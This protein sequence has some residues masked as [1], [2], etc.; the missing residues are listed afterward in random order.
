M[1]KA[2]RIVWSAAR[3]AWVVAS[4]RAGSGGR[5]PL[6][7]KKAACA[8]LLLGSGIASL[9]VYAVTYTGTVVSGPGISQTLNSG[10]TATGVT[11]TSSANQYVSSGGLATSTAVINGGNQ[12]IFAGGSATS[13][14]LSGSRA[15][16]YVS[17]GGVATG[18]TVSNSA[19][20]RVSAGGL[21]TLT[22]LNS[23]GSLAVEPNGSVLGL[24]VNSGG[25]A[26]IAGGSASAITVNSGGFF[27]V[28]GGGVATS[29]NQLA[30]AALNT[31][32][33][34][35]I[36]GTNSLGAFSISAG[37]ANNLLLENTGVFGV[38]SGTSA[39]NTTVGSAGVAVVYSGG[40]A[41]GTTVTTNGSQ[42][43]L[44]GGSAT[45]TVING[46]QETVTGTATGTT[47]NL[48]GVQFV[49]AGGVASGTIINAYGEQD[50][51]GSATSTTVNSSGWQDVF[52][53]ADST[54]VNS[55][56][57]Q[58]V[59]SG[60]SASATTVEG[61]NQFVLN[62]GSVTDTVVNSG[63]QLNT[64][65]SVTSATLNSGGRA[66]LYSG[67]STVA[68]QINSGG[69]EYVNSGTLS[70]SAVLN[71]GGYQVVYAGGEAVAATVSGGTQQVFGEATS[72]TL[73]SGGAQYVYSSGTATGTQ[74]GSGAAQGIYG[75]ANSTTVTSGGA[76]YVYNGGTANWTTVTNNGY[77]NINS[78]G[79][80]SDATVNSGGTL[81]ANDGASATGL[82]LASG[83]V[84]ITSTGAALAGTN[85]LGAFSISGGQAQNVLLENNGFL[86]VKSGDSSIGTVINQGGW[87]YV[88]GHATGTTVNSGGVQ[89]VLGTVTSTTVNSGGTLSVFN[90]GIASSSII[91]DGGQL[92]VSSGGTATDT[93]VAAGGLL[94]IADGG[95]LTLANSS[96]VNDGVTTYDT[97]TSASLNT[98]ISGSGQLT[99]NGSGTLTLGGTFSQSQVNLNDGALIM[100]GLQATTDIVAQSGTS[101]SL[102]NSTTLTG[103]IDPTDVNIDQSSSWNITGDS[104][105]DTL[106][107]AGS[108][109]FVPSQ[110]A[111]TPYTLTVTNLVGNGGTITL[112]TVAGD[113]SSPIDKVVIDGGQA[114]GSTGLLVLN[115]GGLGAQTTGNGIAVIQAINGGTTDVGAFTLNQP[116]VAGAYS[117]SL[118]RNADQSWYLTSQLT[119]TPAT[120]TG[121][122]TPDEGSSDT[123][124]VS[125]TTNYR[126]GM[127]SYA[128]LPSLSLDFDRLVAGT[129]DTRFHYAQDS[130]V[131]GRLVAGHL[132]HAD[133]GSLTGG[134]VP[135]S[136]SAYSFLQLGG[137][138]WQL[139]GA[140]AD[141][142]AGLYGAT[143][144][145]R[146][147]VWRDGGSHAAGTDR[148]TSYTG[149]LYLSGHSHAGLHVDGVLQASHH[150]L[151]TNSNDGT[152][153]STDGTGWLASAEV[154]QAFS[155]GSNLSLE[156]QLQYT[157]QGLS[158][159]DAQ[160]EAASLSWS[161]THRQSVRA[162][163]KVGSSQDAKAKLS[164][165][166]T[167]SI[168]QSYGG[169]S[170]VTASVPGVAGSEASFRSNLSGTGV[171]INGGLDARIRQN[172]T[173]GVQGGWSDALHGAESGGYYGQVRLGVSF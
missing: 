123:T 136:S 43:I 44:A 83:A 107:N 15:Y 134:S 139:D 162:G 93:T 8:V 150:S 59:E 160:D 57:V 143:G 115:R 144:L 10:D 2:Y 164:W 167:P 97:S 29:I 147:D 68:T 166:V 169:H 131:W 116:L 51:Y 39:I 23:G 4:E 155:V 60:A 127:W 137:D 88:N 106:T 99:K 13:T 27:S 26:N 84:L 92:S 152:R 12:T 171:G 63:G 65:G 121:S 1:N 6:A 30:G 5:P 114:T 111:F 56:G 145:M 126:D 159:D 52:G 21:A 85:A 70:T 47:I 14:T 79:T 161:N 36:Y 73:N 48:N 54:T 103:I 66:F 90:G 117:Y 124:P 62:G 135:E 32:T 46:G 19:T 75:T 91:N 132:R 102:V 168:T 87:E 89:S 146:S 81:Y 3:Q 142:R 20:Q 96:F 86:N 37:V 41:L 95:V 158:V 69:I 140:N 165:W 42:Q 58:Y 25:R 34:T 16:Q 104:L 153:L 31:D 9:P 28:A 130:R 71:S 24:T 173:L 108:I 50:V 170:G 35:T 100:D 18:T 101:L 98:D 110:G 156:P 40:T 55:G 82:T 64:Y 141:W 76:E 38:M 94:N 80:A 112:Y 119:Q 151:S 154:G 33:S 53:S 67:G 109:V 72:T 148:D 7:V 105:V 129:A 11:V 149:G 113:S 172:V 77:M 78:G 128:A 133:S 125:G 49:S 122:T 74:I 163:L 157:V 120:D 118:Y 45:S 17:S 61:G 138:L 22:T